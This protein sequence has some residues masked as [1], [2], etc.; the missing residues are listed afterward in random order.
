M[1][2]KQGFLGLLAW[3]T[4]IGLAAGFVWLMY[5]LDTEGGPGYVLGFFFALSAVFA[6]FIGATGPSKGR[7]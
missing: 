2:W 4:F 3:I 6:F 5:F 1:N 7:P